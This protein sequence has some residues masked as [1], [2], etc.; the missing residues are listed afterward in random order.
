LVDEP[1]LE[2]VVQMGYQKEQVLQAISSGPEL[3][4]NMSFPNHEQLRPIIVA[5]NLIMDELRKNQ[6][7][8]QNIVFFSLLNFLD[9]KFKATNPRNSRRTCFSRNSEV[10]VKASV[11]RGNQASCRDAEKL[12]HGIEIP[13]QL[14]KYDG[15]G[16]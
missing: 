5:Y 15:R 4:T 2:K 6:S 9:R 1:S 8:D 16:V 7:N 12:E 11:G 10:L 14:P 3:I 13:P